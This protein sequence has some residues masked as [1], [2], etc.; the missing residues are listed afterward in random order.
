MLVESRST[1]WSLK[2]ECYALTE[3]CS[4]L[5]WEKKIRFQIH[6]HLFL[7]GFFCAFI[8]SLFVAQNKYLLIVFRKIFFIVLSKPA[9]VRFFSCDYALPIPRITQIL[10]DCFGKT[11]FI[12]PPKPIF[13]RF[14]LYV[15]AVLICRIK[16]ISFNCIAKNIFYSSIQTCFYAVHIYRYILY[17]IVVILKSRYT[18]LA[19]HFFMTSYR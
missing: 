2:F 11:I 6:V 14:F 15:Y 5:L 7:C 1:R 18:N 12:A 9:F 16:Q 10:F 4:K 3:K 19:F 17:F 13:L 8:R